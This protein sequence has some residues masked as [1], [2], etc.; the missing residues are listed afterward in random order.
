MILSA[1]CQVFIILTI[2]ILIKF[3]LDTISDR[4]NALGQ[5][6][7]QIC[8]TALKNEILWNTHLQ[9]R[10]HKEVAIA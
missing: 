1:S 6:T 5:V 8:S 9:S 3:F 2:I 10:K 4:Y 7:C